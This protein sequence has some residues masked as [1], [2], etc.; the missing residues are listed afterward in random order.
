M[1]EWL[2]GRKVGA[3]LLSLA[4]PHREATIEGMSDDIPQDLIDKMMVKCARRCCICRRFR[5]TKLQVHHI[6][7]RSQGGANDEDNLIVTCMSCHTDVHSKVPFA[8]RF[9]V[10]ELKG[11]RDT[12]VRMVE[13]GVFPADDIDDAAEVVAGLLR[14]SAKAPSSLSPEATE[15]L[16]RSVNGKAQQGCVLVTESFEG[17]SIM[18]GDDGRTIPN[19]DGRTQAKWKRAV[20]ELREARLLDRHSEGVF[21]VTDEGY[22]AADEIIVSRGQSGQG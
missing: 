4:R 17:L 5:P 2:A 1:D 12:L 3:V 7:E 18:M 6:V 11:H 10:E 13:Q 19:E 8:R 20:R 14:A 22:L 15:M 16:L 9:S 21:E